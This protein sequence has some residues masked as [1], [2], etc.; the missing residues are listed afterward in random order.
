MEKPKLP[1]PWLRG[2][3]TDVPPVQRAVLHALELAKE[4]LERWCG[5][6]TDEELNA[7]PGDIAP[8]AFHIRHIARSTDRLLTYAEGNPLSPEQTSAIKSELN[9]DATR[10]RLLAELNQS[11]DGAVTRIRAFSAEELNQART[12]GRQ[13]MPTTVGGLLV[14]VADHTQRHVGQAVVT[15]KIIKGGM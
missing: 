1:E 9:P 7:R 4:D 14:H 8:I 5:A 13:Q 11:L 12:V 3:L 10:D 15:A 6:M 2:T